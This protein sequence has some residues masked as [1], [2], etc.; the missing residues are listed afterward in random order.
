[1]KRTIAALAIISAAVLGLS[2]CGGSADKSA[3]KAPEASA[4][5]ESK[6]KEE[7]PKASDTTDQ[8]VEDACLQLA[9]PMADSVKAMTSLSSDLLE[10]VSQVSTDPTKAAETIATLQKAGTSVSDAWQALATGFTE[11]DGKVTNPDVKA[12]STPVATNATA[13]ADILKKIYV[14][15]D[16]SAADQLQPASEAFSSSYE[17]LVKLCGPAQ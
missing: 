15:F 17:Q 13:L 9:Q 2:G 7:A 16:F 10:S 4:P 8:S 3:D 14:D 12:A 5:A 6:P 11:F 1:M